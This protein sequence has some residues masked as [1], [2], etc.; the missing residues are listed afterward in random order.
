MYCINC[1]KELPENARFCLYCGA[2][3]NVIEEKKQVS[4]D[5]VLTNYFVNTIPFIYDNLKECTDYPYIYGYINGKVC[6]LDAKDASMVVPCQYDKIVPYFYTESKQFAYSEVQKNKKWGFYQDGNEIIQ[7]IYDSIKSH[8]R[9]NN[10]IY[11]VQ[12]EDKYGIINGG[13]WEKSECK[14]DYIEFKD[15]VIYTRIDIVAGATPEGLYYDSRYGL[16]DYTC[17]ELLSCQYT[18]IE[19]IDNTNGQVFRIFKNGKQGV[20]NAKNKKCTECVYDEIQKENYHYRVTCNNKIGIIN[21]DCKTLVP[22]EYDTVE[23]VSCWYK[24][25]TNNLVGIYGY[26]PCKFDDIKNL[27]G[28]YFLTQKDNKYG[29]YVKDKEI[30]MPLYDTID[31]LYGRVAYNTYHDFL[32]YRIPAFDYRIVVIG[33]KVKNNGQCHL[34][35]LK[36]EAIQTKYFFED[37]NSIE[38]D[39]SQNAHDLEYLVSINHKWGI[40]KQELIYDNL[41]LKDGISKLDFIEILPCSFEEITVFSPEYI[42]V[43]KS[44][45]FGIMSRNKVNGKYIYVVSC[46]HKE[47]KYAFRWGYVAV[48]KNDDGYKLYSYSLQDIIGESF[49]DIELLSNYSDKDRNQSLDIGTYF[50]IRLNDK[51]GIV[52]VDIEKNCLIP[53]E[54]DDVEYFGKNTYK[55]SQHGKY[56]AAIISTHSYRIV[57]CQYD[58]VEYFEKADTCIFEIDGKYSFGMKRLYDEIEYTNYI[59]FFRVKKDGKYGITDRM[60]EILPCEFDN[61]KYFVC[62]SSMGR[63]ITWEITHNGNVQNIS[64]REDFNAFRQDYL[65][66]KNV[67]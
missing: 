52:A 66:Q 16:L 36:G 59:S 48:G 9:N 65:K 55:L 6:L 41:N 61:I 5:E 26:I 58:N 3:V 7:C 20:F 35:N 60:F 33:F 23:C 44:R 56:G 45:A 46:L 49:D 50:K 34:K 42:R 28:D 19:N 1:G 54:Y 4:N 10:R 17:E 53:C 24:V 18:G 64:N 13:T 11:I 27:T 37:I 63:V 39:N 30:L 31:F 32:S 67:K 57:Q 47:I 62:G 15:G 38:T 14:Y 2:K 22:S 40:F 12:H 43:K 51:Y 29:L 25:T 21:S 8:M